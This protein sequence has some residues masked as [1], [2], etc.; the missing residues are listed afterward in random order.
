MTEETKK[1]DEQF[2]SKDQWLMLILIVFTAGF[3]FLNWSVSSDQHDLAKNQFAPDYMYSVYEP[4][5]EITGKVETFF[6][7]ENVGNKKGY[8]KYYI[9]SPDFWISKDDKKDR[10]INDGY[11]IGPSKVARVF[12]T[13]EPPETTPR[14]EKTK[15]KISV[16][17]SDGM[18]FEDE[19]T[20][21]LVGNEK[22]VLVK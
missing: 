12:F 11:G 4:P 14:P 21:H 22:Y 17:T 8:Y 10:S 9:S 19:F 20:Y 1:Q 3:G 16:N 7:L 2:L 18:L 13:I 6:S 15:L 5:L